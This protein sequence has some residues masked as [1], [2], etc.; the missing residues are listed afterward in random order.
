MTANA[1][2]AA[3]LPAHED[4]TATANPLSLSRVAPEDVLVFESV[5]HGVRLL[6]ELG[7][8]DTEP[9]DVELAVF[10]F[11]FVA[12]ALRGARFFVRG[13]AVRDDGAP[14][15]RSRCSAP[16]PRAP[17]RRLVVAAGGRRHPLGHRPR[18]PA[19]HRRVPRSRLFTQARREPTC[20]A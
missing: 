20:C 12:G 3:S 14:R 8:S 4:G 17:R 6:L 10:E 16:P 9:R 5:L 19:V 13:L 7:L 15:S 18:L 2:L 11:F 1:T